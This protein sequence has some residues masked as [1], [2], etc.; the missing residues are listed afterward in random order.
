MEPRPLEVAATASPR[1]MTATGRDVSIVV[2]DL[3]ARRRTPLLANHSVATIAMTLERDGT[4]YAFCG[5]GCRHVFAEE[6]QREM[7]R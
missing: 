4:L 3:S 6:S 7:A 5:T 1:A 2:M